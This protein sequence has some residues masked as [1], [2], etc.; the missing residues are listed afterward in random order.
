MR[1]PVGVW[2]GLVVVFG[3]MGIL[4]LIPGIPR[5]AE[6]VTVELTCPSTIPSGGGPLTITL[7]LKNRTSVSKTIARSALAVHLANLN[8]LGPFIVPLSTTLAPHATQVVPYVATNFPAGAASGGILATIGVAVLD[9]ANNPLGGN[10]C[11]VRV[12]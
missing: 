2:R 9:G 1:N 5:A 10:Y 6:S 3:V 4:L 11:L 8:L 12:L 7:T